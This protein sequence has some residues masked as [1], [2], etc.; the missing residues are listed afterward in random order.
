MT[1]IA[2]YRRPMLDRV[3]GWLH[4]RAVLK[5]GAAKIFHMGLLTEYSGNGAVLSLS[6]LG[7]AGYIPNSETRDSCTLRGFTVYLRLRRST[8]RSHGRHRSFPWLTATTNPN[9]YQIER[10]WGE[11]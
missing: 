1:T 7:G 5:I 2:I 11:R 3:C 10:T 9:L 8:G 4:T 6:F